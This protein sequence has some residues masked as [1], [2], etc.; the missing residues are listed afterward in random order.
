MT[1]TVVVADADT[2]FPA[3]MRGLLIYLDYEGAIRLHWSP[4]ILDEVSRALVDA[5]RKATLA[6]AKANEDR[7]R[8]ALPNALVAAADVQAQFKAVAPAVRSAKDVHVAACAYALHALRAYPGNPVVALVT[9]NARDFRKGALADLG[10]ALRRPDE[11]LPGLLDTA[12]AEFAAA[13]QRFRMDLAS[14]PAPEA[15]L[16]LLHKS[17]LER[18]AQKAQ[19]LHQAR[20]LRL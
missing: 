5:G 17:G 18:T 7:M 11:F 4:M 6:D 19:D 2:L 1:A 9:R 14:Q 15:L 8:D 16:A 12:P 20:R 10:I 3:A 13:F